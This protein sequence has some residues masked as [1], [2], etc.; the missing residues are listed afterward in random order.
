VLENAEC[1]LHALLICDRLFAVA[2][3]IQAYAPWNLLPSGRDT[4]FRSLTHSSANLVLRVT[5]SF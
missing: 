2:F 4:V 1:C 5:L 3:V